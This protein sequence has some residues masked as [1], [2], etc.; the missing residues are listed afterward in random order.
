MG[1]RK[2]ANSTEEKIRKI[3]RTSFAR[4][5]IDLIGISSE[6][7]IN[8]EEESENENEKES[9]LITRFVAILKQGKILVPVTIQGNNTEE[10]IEKIITQKLLEYEVEF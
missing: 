1:I 10:E 8:N 6:R 4:K 9:G 5:Y 7:E 2:N 3:Y